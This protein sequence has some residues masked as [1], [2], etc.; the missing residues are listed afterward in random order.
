[1]FPINGS[2][3][4]PPGE[5]ELVE[6]VVRFEAKT[7]FSNMRLKGYFIPFGFYIHLYTVQQI[8]NTWH[9]L[10][11]AKL[12]HGLFIH[13][14]TVQGI[15][16]PGCVLLGSD[17]AHDDT[18][19]SGGDRLR[20]RNADH[21][22]DVLT[23]VGHTSQKLPPCHKLPK[24]LWGVLQLLDQRLY[25]IEQCLLVDVLDALGGHLVTAQVLQDVFEVGAWP[26]NEE[27]PFR[28]SPEFG[29]A[30]EHLCQLGARVFLQGAQ[31]CRVH[32]PT[33]V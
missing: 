14:Q 31:R 8:R 17:H 21:Q 26:V 10:P 32:L 13:V 1:M 25:V 20:P 19:L 7:F 27:P 29:L 11:R 6:E 18:G 3:L 12:H 24:D 23:V 9:S 28:V 33:N 5:Q 4:L 15:P 16:T 22:L 30:G 2:T